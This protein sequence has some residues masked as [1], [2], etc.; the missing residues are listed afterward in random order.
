MNCVGFSAPYRLFNM[1]GAIDTW[2]LAEVTEDKG[3]CSDS[4]P[5][6]D[7]KTRLVC[8]ECRPAGGTYMTAAIDH[9]FYI[10][11]GERPSFRKFDIL[12][13]NYL[14]TSSDHCPVVLDMDF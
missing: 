3:S 11:R 1:M 8:R 4:Y 14:C 6:F 2:P 13:E 9:I 7:Q 12:H 10:Q 5:A